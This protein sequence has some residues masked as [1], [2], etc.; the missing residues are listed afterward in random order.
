MSARAA[1]I[2]SRIAAP[3]LEWAD[4]PDLGLIVAMG[5]SRIDVKGSVVG[6]TGQSHCHVE[7][8][9]YRRPPAGTALKKTS[10]DQGAAGHCRNERTGSSPQQSFTSA[11]RRVAAHARN[12]RIWARQRRPSAELSPCKGFNSGQPSR[13][14]V[15]ITFQSAAQPEPSWP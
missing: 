2:H 10:G 12:A 5:S 13:L 8:R 6:G 7:T 15:P 11:L 4:I 9:E 14:S 1:N 3:P